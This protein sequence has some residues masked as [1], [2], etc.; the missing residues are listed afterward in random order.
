MTELCSEE[1]F[2]NR[3]LD[4][5]L[6]Q[7]TSSERL[8][9]PFGDSGANAPSSVGSWLDLLWRCNTRQ[10]LTGASVPQIRRGLA[11]AWRLMLASRIDEALEL[12]ERIELQIDDASPIIARRFRGATQ[13]LRAAGLAFQ[14]DSLAALAIAISHLTSGG[15]KQDNH[16]ASTLCRLGLWQLG[17]FDLLY[18]LP[19]PQP[20]AR[21]SKSWATSAMLDLSIEAAVALDQLLLSTAKRLA[22]DALAIAE[23][24]MKEARG[25]ATLP[26]CLAAQ[27]LYE[28]GCLDQAEMILRDRLPVINAEGPI[29]SALRAY[30]V[31]TRIAK[32]RMQYDFAAVLLRDAEALGQRRGWRR[33]VAA[34]LAER[35]S[36][37]LQR[38][39]ANEARLCLE[40][41][42]R[43]ATTDHPRSG[44]CGAEILRY[45]TLTR[46]RVSWAETPSIEAVMGLRRLYHHCIETQDFYAGCELAVELAEWLAVVGESE[47][48]DA[49]FFHTIKSG[50]KAGLYQAFSGRGV[51]LGGLL[52]RAYSRAESFGPTDP[53]VLPFLGSLLSRW[54]S[55]NDGSSPQDSSR[56]SDTLT[57][58]ERDILVMISQGFSNKRSARTLNISPETVKSHVKRIFIKLA[59]STRTE[60]VSRAGSLGLL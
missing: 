8:Q 16:A 3:G 25:L 22:S 21:W 29:E 24:V 46:L 36:L 6:G 40:N 4:E 18:S 45:R 12:I 13:L 55:R 39:R 43:C 57:S 9:T 54:V 50:A 31:L 19:R 60:A 14:D 37:L 53:E 33:L 44:H 26:A 41:L 59:V 10:N 34:C 11:R 20:R 30:I 49:L 32:Q 52:K 47:E 51:E 2:Q 58:R 17:K 35:A 48:A 42:D 1:A 56:V 27:V 7:L 28:E 15:R 23:T 38:G 5:H